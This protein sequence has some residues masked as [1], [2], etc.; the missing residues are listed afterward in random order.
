MRAGSLRHSI[1]IRRA[2][3]VIDETG[4]PIETWAD[5][6]TLNAEQLECSADDIARRF[7]D[8]TETNYVFRTR[9]FGNVGIADQVQYGGAFYAI[10]KLAADDRKRW[11]E[12]SILRVGP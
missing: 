3:R 8:S 1:T 7:G 6:A 9:W 10:K 5:V 2:T 4:T 11:L 12:L